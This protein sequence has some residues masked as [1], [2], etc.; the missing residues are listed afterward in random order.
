[1]VWGA[2]SEEVVWIVK[3]V[4]GKSWVYYISGGACTRDR[5]KRGVKCEW[6]ID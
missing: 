6:H 4:I 5:Q 2:Q 3:R 1:M